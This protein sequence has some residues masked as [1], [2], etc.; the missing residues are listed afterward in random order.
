[1]SQDIKDLAIFEGYAIRRIWADGRWWFAVV[2]VIAA[3][4]ASTNPGQYWRTLKSRLLA[5]G[6]NETVAICNSFKMPA[7][8]GKMRNTD[9]AD[10]KI[11]LRIIQS[12]PS[13]KAEPFKQW[14]AQVGAEVIE[15]RED[16]DALYQDWRQ[17]AIESYTSRGYS[18][19]W[20]EQRVDSITVRNA[21]TKEWSVRGIKDRE[22][23]ILTDR[24]H[25]DSF[26]LT[27]QAHMG[28][29]NFPVTR[30]GHRVM[31]RGN[32]RDGMTLMELAIVMF[33]ENIVRALH[34]AHGSQG[35]EEIADDVSQGGVITHEHRELLER[36]LGLP[37][38]SPVNAIPATNTLWGELLPPTDE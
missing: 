38:V 17:H 36:Q 33:G 35:F 7:A 14:L 19:E 27:V 10:I 2:D 23:S 28:L 37:I 1:M 13:P 11:M 29:K 26:G 32:L 22:F 30:Q 31:Y 6:A 5:E 34:I 4:T 24:L 21:L 15:E 9:C 18:R 12:I 3:L 25:M 8:D 20:A 16:L